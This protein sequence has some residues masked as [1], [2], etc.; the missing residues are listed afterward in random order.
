MNWTNPG[1]GGFYDDLGKRTGQPHLVA[2]S[3][4]AADP[5]FR[6]TPLMHFEQRPRARRAWLDQ[7]M[8]LFDAPLTMRYAGL[9]PAAHY[10]LKVVYGGGPIR[11]MANEQTPIHAAITRPYQ[12]LEFDIPV[13]ATA[14]GT[15]T[16]TW[17]RS[18]GGGGA[19]RG[20]QVA[21]VWLMRRP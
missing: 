17:T 18:P 4:Y 6:S 2:G 12:P 10:K 16:L 1:P 8:A 13:T 9:D 15:L 21:E 19:G 5:E 7:A 14:A 20:C 3:R 11:L